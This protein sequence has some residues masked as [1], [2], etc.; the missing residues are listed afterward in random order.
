VSITAAG[1]ATISTWELMT[2][3][4]PL[5]DRPDQMRRKEVVNTL[6]F[7]QMVTYKKFG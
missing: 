2:A 5:E 6:L 1:V 7:D 4:W 3:I